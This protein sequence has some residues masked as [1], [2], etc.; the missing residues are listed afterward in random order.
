MAVYG[1]VRVS[2]IAQAVEGLSLES[3]EKQLQG[4]SLMTG[5]HIDKMFIEKAVSGAK[6]FASRPEG[7]SLYNVLREGDAVL[8]SKLDREPSEAHETRW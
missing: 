6:P 3:Q 7:S 5:M 2:T 1:Y 8:V 4:Y